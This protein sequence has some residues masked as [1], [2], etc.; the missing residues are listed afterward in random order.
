MSTKKGVQEKNLELLHHYKNLDKKEIVLIGKNN[1]VDFSKT[2]SCYNPIN[3][4]KCGL[5]DACLLRKKGF[6]EAN[7]DDN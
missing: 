4:K 2:S 3:I 5:C 7:L 1:G 6:D